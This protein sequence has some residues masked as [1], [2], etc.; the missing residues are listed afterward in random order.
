MMR[1]PGPS[2]TWLDRVKRWWRDLTENPAARQARQD[3]E[4]ER[5]WREPP[6]EPPPPPE[7]A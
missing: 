6:R 3:R 4:N 2:D 5:L 1:G 7:G